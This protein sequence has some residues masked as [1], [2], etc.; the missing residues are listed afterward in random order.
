V[1]LNIAAVH[2]AV[3][4]AVPDREC[5][6]WRD[7]RH[8][9]AQV[10]DRTRRLANVLGA[11][12]LGRR[13][14]LSSCQG[15]E[16]PQDLVAL[17]LLNGNEYLE[18]MLGAYKA[19]AA[20]FNV[21]YR[22]VADE[23][24]YVLRD[25]GTRAVI[26][27]GRYA[28]TLAAVLDR[29]PTVELL[30]RVDD[31]SGD[32]LLPGALDYEAALADASPERPDLDWSGD[33]LYVVYTGGT[34]GRPKG[35]LWRQADFVVAALGTRRRDGREF[36]DLAELAEAASRNDRLRVL[37]A[38]PLM[39][40]AAHWNALSAWIAGGTVIMQDDTAR[41][42]PVDVLSTCQREAVSSLLIVGDAFARPLLDELARTPYDLNSLRFLLTGG[43]I[44]SPSVK[45]ELVERLPGL[46]VVDV[47]GSSE[48]GRQGVHRSGQ[49]GRPSHRSAGSFVPSDTTAVIS[50]DRSRFLAAGERELG[51]LAQRGR[52]PRGYLGDPDKTNA[53]FPLVKGERVAVAGDRARL[54][55]NG[56]LEL[57]G[58]DS[59]TINT[60]GEKVFAEEVEQAIKHHP[61]VY[62]ALVVGR[63]SPRWGQE[64][65]AV[66]QL[67][68]GQ[69][70]SAALT[71]SIL[72][73]AGQQ[74]ARYKLP[75]ELLYRA[76]VVRSPSGKPD[77]AWATAEAT[78]PQP[79]R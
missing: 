46:S 35:V 77:Y 56:T 40:G 57:H 1:E 52:V 63:P 9:W 38:P 65:V 8:S 27:H 36:E 45:A 39:H 41:L 16:S 31:G 66:V 43:A 7:R 29:V 26:Y 69:A 70:G 13:R 37:P 64:I 50:E 5:L 76:Q 32:E 61:A 59:A 18:G 44:L 10:T 58:R 51:W 78:A 62:D 54:A 68:A 20:P 28:E 34:T 55:A 19:A 3:A 71:A 6:V 4:A 25:A 17:Y 22:Y 60:G 11:H 73:V 67:R 75:K 79:R 30:L 23:L 2:E 42:D 33:D 53:T 15:W 12:G 74:L 24:A 49:S 21:N 48:T 14:P 72:E 47:L